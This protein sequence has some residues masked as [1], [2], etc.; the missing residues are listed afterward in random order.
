MMTDDESN[1]EFST[2]G[3]LWLLLDQMKEG[4][5]VNIFLNAHVSHAC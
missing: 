2:K 3:T 5:K 4:A 1:Q